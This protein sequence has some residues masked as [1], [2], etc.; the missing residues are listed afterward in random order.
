MPRYFPVEATV[1]GRRYTGD[2]CLMQGDR[3]CVRSRAFG[4][5]PA[6][7]GGARPEAIAAKVLEEIVRADWKKR[8]DHLKHE[9]RELA[10]LR[11]KH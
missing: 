9:E 7:L 4:S 1:D 2:W 10:K 8:S 5:R 11:R 3:I 6:E